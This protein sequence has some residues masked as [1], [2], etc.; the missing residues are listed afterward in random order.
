MTAP[1]ELI[2]FRVSWKSCNVCRDTIT[3]KSPREFCQHLRDFHCSKEGGSYMCHYG[4]NGVCPS[5]PLDGVND[6]DYDDHVARDH[7]FGGDAGKCDASRKASCNTTLPSSVECILLSSSEPSIVQDQFK[8]TVY[9]ASVN[10]AAVLNDPR[11]AKREV[12]FFTKTWGNDFEKTSILPSAYL[13]EIT[14]EHFQKYIKKTTLRHK[15]HL[16]NQQR[17]C[18][19]HKPN[20]DA[21]P[22]HIKQIED[23]KAELSQVPK[24]FLLPNFSLENPDTFNAVFP[25]TQVE[26]S[27]T[28]Y[29]SESHPSSKLLQERLSHYLDIVEV[30]IAKQISM[31]SEAFFH[32]MTSHDE[33]QDQLLHTCQAIKKLRDKVQTLDARLAV[34]PLKIMNRTRTRSNCIHLHNKLKLMST[35][36]QTQPTIQ[37]LLSNN[38]FVGALDLIST[39]QEILSQEL[40]GLH[41]FRHLGSQLAELEKLIEK[42]LQADYSKY[43]TSE[44]NRP[45]TD[46]EV[47]MQEEKLVSIMFGLLRQDKLNFVDVYREE[48]FTALKAIIKQTVIEAV[49]EADDISTE[50]NVGS[51][52][53]QM[54][55]LSYGQW[56]DLLRRIFLNVMIL[57]R[58]AQAF[59][60]IVSDV[61]GIAAGRTKV[62]TPVS[63]PTHEGQNP[64]EEPKHLSTSVSD[65]VDVVITNADFVQLSSALKEMLC[66]ICDN[67]HDRIVKVVVA[68]AKDGFLERL[69]SSEFV[70][71]CREVEG[72]VAD[73]EGVCGRRSM[74][75]R[76]SLQNQANKFVA[77]FH[78]ERKQ[79][80]SLILDN[81]RWKQ[82]D[83][84]SEFQ[85]LVYHISQSD[86]LSLPERRADSDRRPAE[87]I[88]VDGEQFAV[89]G[90]VLLLLKMVVEYCQCLN[91]I[92]TA[93]PDLL[94]R[95]IDLLKTFNSRTCQLVL[96]AGALQLVGLKKITTRTLALA[97]RALQ[98]VVHFMPRVQDHF[99]I[100]LPQRNQN[101][102]K[103]LGQIVKDYNNHIEEISNKLVSI[104]DNM[105]EPLLS[106]YEVKA[107]VPSVCFRSICK[108]I[109]KLHEALI[110]VL[111]SNQVKDIFLRIDCSFK[112]ILAR[113]LSTLG[114]SND[115]GPQHGLV[116]S[117]LVFYAG[118][119]RA[120]KG[121]EE[122][123][124][125]VNDVW[126]P[127]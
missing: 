63:S 124:D 41:S 95:L 119:Y 31:K 86:I 114:V 69:S 61:I 8:W 70:T 29:H 101:M 83:V 43:V 26:E 39:S 25:W 123:S 66:S 105:M 80:L 98:L 20:L 56:M 23:N 67:A 78:E 118:S 68:R 17:L 50:G 28:P 122:L 100:M 21:F 113:K 38:D 108:Q 33:L 46:L 3:F 106:K 121:V 22:S 85:D 120:L 74:S 76:G 72:F 107:P 1:L 42:M 16:R 73:C 55:L 71:L 44:L 82:A 53:D 10:L 115:G 112:A 18:E 84:P 111:P 13:P 88:V 32:A 79:K 19:P 91:D 99:Q 109:A 59:H 24:L 2:K 102:M 35:I 49:S 54:R 47:L 15:K 9:K 34:G 62:P 104:M 81:E 12:D 5:L 14:I 117:D 97:S 103:H 93:A 37:L 94:T 11:L 4:M 7:V 6:K 30:Q 89:V 51:L 64:L 48:A 60:G 45:F 96:G 125:S 65:D 110:D 87:Y 77:R 58:R 52:A 40:A 126:L 90:T 92:P 36:H 75:L 116:T 127:R 57:L 27:R